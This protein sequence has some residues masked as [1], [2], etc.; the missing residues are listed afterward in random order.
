M[1][2]TMDK[3]EALAA[4]YE[5]ERARLLALE[6]DPERATG[7]YQSPVMGEGSAS[8]A[9]MLIGEAPG[10][11]EAKLG[12]PFVGKAGRQ[13]DELLALSK[14]GRE[15]IYITNAVK[16]RPVT[17][18]KTGMKNRTP[19]RA[20]VK[21]CLPVLREEIALLKPMVIATLGNTPLYALRLL[22]ALE[23]GTVGDMHGKA[24][25][26]EADGHAFYLFPLYHPASVIYNRQLLPVL[27]ADLIALG[28]AVNNR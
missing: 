2:K 20:E 27:K 11:E 7:L 6:S 12:R 4:L 16:Y 22:C 26:L 13:L 17:H 15:G 5:A 9:L 10:A 28:Q 24:Y 21:Q 18:T 14:I 3:R 19:G 25:A 1:G 23:A 8:P